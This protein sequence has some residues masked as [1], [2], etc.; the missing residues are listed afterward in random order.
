M[1]PDNMG[2]LEQR[3][4]WKPLEIRFIK[5]AGMSGT[6]HLTVNALN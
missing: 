4:D 6:E 5:R 3:R 1:L 2:I